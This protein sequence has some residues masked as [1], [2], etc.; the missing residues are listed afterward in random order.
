WREPAGEGHIAVTHAFTQETIG[1]VPN[2]NGEDVEQAVQAARAAFPAWAD[3][4]VQARGALLHRLR[5]QLAERADE[6][7]RT[8]S[9]EVGTP[10]KIS[11]RIQVGLPLETLRI[12]QDILR[13]FQFETPLD[14]SVVRRE[15]IGVVACITPWNYPL[16]Q[17]VSKVAP[18]LAAGCTVVLKPSAVA[19]LSAFVLAE[20]IAKAGFPPGVFNLV[21]GR[22]AQV[23]EALASHPEVDMVSFTGSTGA[24]QQISRSAAGTIKR[25]SLELG[26]KSASVVLPGADLG[27]AVKSN[28]NSCFLN[29]GQTCNALTRMLVPRQ[30]Y[31]AAVAVAAATAASFVAGDP[32]DDKVKFGPLATAAQRDNVLRYIRQGLESGAELVCGG[33]EP[34]AG[35]TTGF[36][37][38]PTIFGKVDPA[39]AIAQEEIFG[40][41]LSIICYDTQEQAI[42]IAN[43]TPFGLAAAV[44]AATDDE[45]R[46]VARQLRAGQVDI[47][48]GAF[49]ARAPF[50]GYK[51]SGNG[52]E[53]GVAGFEEF[54]ET[55]AMQFRVTPA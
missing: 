18:A 11:R 17:V 35:V 20:E 48:G 38:Q 41:V 22:G 32:A 31:A 19:P 1:E 55:K 13:S 6:L 28:V 49:N 8:I 15:A 24:G 9:A 29:A 7:A 12:T 33:L 14:H 16:H 3:Q 51:Q 44:W 45:A 26:G 40:P 4:P 39:S 34:P 46:A 43:G 50:G 23:G 25:L 30:D 10:L 36:F 5:E 27:S 21:M 54:L 42:A 52:R 2:G 53:L 47:N 37:V